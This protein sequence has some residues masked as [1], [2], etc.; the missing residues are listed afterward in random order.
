[1]PPTLAE[2]LGTHLTRTHTSVNRLTKLSGIPQRTISNWLNGQIRKPHQWQAL[3]K[4]ALALHLSEPETDALLQSAG[5]PPLSNLRNQATTPADLALLARS[6]ISN[7]PPPLLPAPFQAIADLPTFVGRESEL[8]TVTRAVLDGGRA[9]ICGLRGMGGVGKTALAARLAYHLRE[10]FPDGVLWA[11][12]DTSDPLSVLAAFADAYGK[13]VSQYKDVE[14]RAAVVRSLL[15]EKR[16]LIVLDNVETSAQVRPMLPP[17]TG[18]CAVLITTRQDLPV[19]DGWARLTLEPF[20]AASEE[21]LALFRKYLGDGFV[22]RHRSALREI[23]AL[24]GHLPLALAIAAGRLASLRPRLAD[25]TDAVAALLAAMQESHTRLDALTRDDLGVRASFEVSYAALSPEMQRFFAALGVFGGEDFGVESIAYVTETTIENAETQ[26]KRLLSLSLVQESR[27]GRWRLHPLLRDY[28][29]Q[30]LAAESQQQ[31]I[32]RLAEYYIQITK[33]LGD[34]GYKPLR[35]ETGNIINVIEQV[36]SLEQHAL[37]VR[38]FSTFHSIFDHWGLHHVLNVIK[39]K[40]NVL[41]AAEKLADKSELPRLFFAM[42]ATEA[43]SGYDYA[44]AETYALRAI[45]WARQLEQWE[46]LARCMNL[47]SAL[48][49]YQ[50]QR[51]R[52]QALAAEAEAVARQHNIQRTLASLVNGRGIRAVELGQFAEAEAAFKE[53]E[54]YCRQENNN[55]WLATCL[56]NLGEVAYRQRQYAQADAYFAEALR[57]S[58]QA[59]GTRLAAVLAMRGQIAAHQG[60]VN[61]AES[62]AQEALAAQREGG[63]PRGISNILGS[64]GDIAQELGQDEQARQ[65]WQEGLDIARQI[66]L[67]NYIS[68]HA[69]RLG[70][71]HVQH[72]QLETAEELLQEAWRYASELKNEALLANTLF[73]LAQL[74]AA[75]GQHDEACRLAEESIAQ[76]ERIHDWHA[77]EVRAWMKSDITGL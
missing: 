50:G 69:W 17:S 51:E 18:R 31:A 45:E 72:G 25:E 1:M 22:E 46:T 30:K 66:G 3:V 65:Y 71:W 28:A 27:G 40:T 54:A 68:D 57:I 43:E 8:E 34:Q 21:S 13:D 58:E 20:D 15:A 5:H 59:D 42:A 29:R 53:F 76:F 11:R 41:A 67:K 4:V 10:Q 73:G 23:A 60:E 12:L 64:V 47:L 70:R 39:L 55:Y 38:V 63:H 2:L 52:T 77:E 56:R 16:A 33:N 6:P 48:A 24:V 37:V 61:L 26:L 32:T 14:S 62:Y 75:R 19:L 74:A 7:S 9:A 36:A 49:W 35:P 44:Q